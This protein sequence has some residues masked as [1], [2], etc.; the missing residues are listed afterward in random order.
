MKKVS[1]IAGMASLALAGVWS[2]RRQ[3]LRRAQRSACAHQAHDKWP[4]VRARAKRTTTTPTITTVSQQLH[5]R[6]R[7]RV[8]SRWLALGLG[9]L[10]VYSLS[11]RKRV[12]A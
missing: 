10:G 4:D 11:R 7:S 1:L 5:R 6:C 9:G 2:L 12:K 8:R 3:R